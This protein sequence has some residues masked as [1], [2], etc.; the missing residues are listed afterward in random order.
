MQHTLNFLLVL[1][2]LSLFWPLL[3]D[4][5]QWSPS[6]D[7]NCYFP[8]VGRA[9]EID[10]I[11]G[12]TSGQF[13]GN[14]FIDLGESPVGT[15][16]R[17][18]I[19]GL[20]G[21]IPFVSSLDVS[22]G[23]N[24]KK[25][26]VGK[27]YDLPIW[28]QYKTAN[29]RSP[30]VKDLL[31]YRSIGGLKIYW[32]DDNGDY[33][34]SRYTDLRSGVFRNGALDQGDYFELPFI[35]R[36]SSDSVDDIVWQ[37]STNYATIGS[38]DS[39]F[40]LWYKG[41]PDMYAK[42]KIAKPDTMLFWSPVVIDTMGSDQ[43]FRRFWQGDFRGTGRQ[44]IVAVDE[45]LNFFFYA[46]D[47]PF[48][49]EKFKYSLAYDTLLADWQNPT[50]QPRISNTSWALYPFT[51]RVL[52]KHVSDS[53]VDLFIRMRV[54]DDK[55]DAQYIFRGGSEFGKHRLT[56]DSAEAVLH[57]PAEY[58][59]VNWEFLVYWGHTFD[60]C[61]DMT[62]SGNPVIH[63][64]SHSLETGFHFF[65]VLGT[66]TDDKIDIFWSQAIES[67]GR[68]AQIDADKDKYA[69][70]LIAAPRLTTMKD[71]VDRDKK[72]IGS[73]QILHGSPMIPNRTNPKYLSVRRQPRDNALTIRVEGDRISVSG[74]PDGQLSVQVFNV[75]GTE[76]LQSELL[77]INGKCSFDRDMLSSGVYFLKVKTAE[78][79]LTQK[80]TVVE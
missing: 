38:K 35:T 43:G 63:T 74:L 69:D 58:D 25:R 18:L 75:L 45:K 40:I 33:D 28:G 67:D 54:G 52:P 15:P 50:R 61:G 78:G 47:P 12:S 27:T 80:F 77:A 44:D 34:T 10:T 13:M 68:A 56:Y 55:Y 21:N 62:G 4:A 5:Q 11:Y 60:Y 24:L 26:K 71:R 32:A 16:K 73:L 70:V 42:G 37:A 1:L 7:S 20:P 30:K 8:V 66:A 29:L 65:Y 3:S 2:M 51:A 79:Y 57:H 59:Q 19:S 36:L 49:L 23:V 14:T 31:Y 53:S 39:I 41:G 17:M 64:T 46:N 48:T 9:G 6:L 72:E 22:N 76:V